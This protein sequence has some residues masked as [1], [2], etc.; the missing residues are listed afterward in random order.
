M[1]VKDA[2]EE[3]KNGEKEAS[4][5]HPAVQLGTLFTPVPEIS[6][7]QNG[8]G[9]EEEFTW[10]PAGFLTSFSLIISASPA[11]AGR[12]PFFPSLWMSH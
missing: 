9:R 4:P 7:S 11:Q 5:A 8:I 12:V 3:H 10:K 2:E 6:H 1:G